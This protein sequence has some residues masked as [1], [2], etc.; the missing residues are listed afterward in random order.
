MKKFL[1]IISIIL[2]VF[3][4]L[5]LSIPKIKTTKDLLKNIMQRPMYEYKEYPLYRNNIK[6]HLDRIDVIGK[7]S[8]KNILLIHGVT[9]SSHEFDIKYK[10]YSLA[11]ALAREGYSVW[12][13]D[14]AG[15]GKS[16]ALTDGFM[17]NTD[18]AAE[19]INSA[20][21][22]I[23]QITGQ[24]NIDLLGWSWGTVTASK[25]AS[26][27]GNHLNKLV[28]YAPIING[29]GKCDIKEPFHHNTWEHAAEDFQRDT[30]GHIDYSTIDP[31]VAEL[32]A[33]SCWHY[34]GDLSPN[35]GRRDICVDE[36]KNLIDLSK[37]NVPT[38]IIYGDKDP[39]LNYKLI[40]SAQK[41]LPV[42]SSVKKI[43]GGSHV[44][45]IEKPYYK[46]FQKDIINFLKQ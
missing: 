24:D 27:H 36:F 3:I 46:A 1:I 34:D 2:I 29:I 40:N 33:S 43:S 11:R 45:F 4:L 31:V 6:L 20:V 28:L 23:T 39:Y 30:N 18:Y 42:G 44:V 32:W 14:I 35:G 5:V 8:N 37:I 19:D 22:K 9:Y 21:E 10:D 12:R 7:S 15:F 25:F 41:Q 38:L 16:D 13:L 26:K 17:P